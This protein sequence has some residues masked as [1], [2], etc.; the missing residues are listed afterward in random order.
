MI[1]RLIAAFILVIAFIFTGCTGEEV[2]RIPVNAL[3]TDSAHF[4]IKESQSI[5]LKKGEKLYTWADMDMEYEGELQL[6]FAI[7][8]IREGNSLG[9]VKVDPMK[10]DMTV[11]SIETTLGGKTSSRYMG[12]MD[13]IEIPEDGNYV[14]KALLSSNGNPT[15][16]LNK[17]EVVLKK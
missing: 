12:R 3:T 17:A 1:T 7:E 13:F 6:Q 2:G 14:F 10:N 8:L 16:R 11:N 9:V 15:L 4:V 5:S